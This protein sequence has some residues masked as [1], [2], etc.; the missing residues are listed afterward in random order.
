VK[1]IPHPV[2]LILQRFLAVDRRDAIERAT[3]GTQAAPGASAGLP[4]SDAP[5]V[6]NFRSPRETRRLDGDLTAI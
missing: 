5:S 2:H 1:T 4:A 6:R 3:A